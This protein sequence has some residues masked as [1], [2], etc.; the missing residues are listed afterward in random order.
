MNWDTPTLEME[1]H[2]GGPLASQRLSSPSA[3]PL[4]LGPSTQETQRFPGIPPASVIEQGF[5]RTSHHLVEGKEEA[6]G[7]CRG[8]GRS[9]G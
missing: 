7:G 8:V 3:L 6:F 9:S 4:G 5:L 1:R 2:S